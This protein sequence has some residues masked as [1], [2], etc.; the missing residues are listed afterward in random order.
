MRHNIL[1][2]INSE[3]V[4]QFKL[5]G[6]QNHPD[7]TG[8]QGDYERADAFKALMKSIAHGGTVTWRDILH[9]EVLEAFEATDPEQLKTELI[10]VAAVAASW[11]EAIDRRARNG[12]GTEEHRTGAGS[13]D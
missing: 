5:W 1:H 2:L 11:V 10:Q 9:E 6:E 4:R 3:I 7:G 8:M 13:G 12:Q